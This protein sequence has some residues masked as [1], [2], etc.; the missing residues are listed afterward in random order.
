[1]TVKITEKKVINFPVER[2]KQTLQNIYQKKTKKR[3]QNFNISPKKQHDLSQQS[4]EAMLFQFL[5]ILC[6]LI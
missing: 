5:K 4:S 3:Y 6:F 1:M 2:K